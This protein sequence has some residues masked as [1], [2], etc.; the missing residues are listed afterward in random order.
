MAVAATA[1]AASL[2]APAMA[3]DGEGYFGADIGYTDVEAHKIYSVGSLDRLKEKDGFELGAFVGY[4]FGK[5]RTELEVAYEEFDPKTLTHVATGSVRHVGGESHITTAMIN[6]LF[7]LG[8]QDGIGL[9]IGAGVGRAFLSTDL[10]GASGAGLIND[11]D[12]AWAYQGIAEFRV[13]VTTWGEIGLKYKYLN[14]ESF[15]LHDLAGNRH[16]TEMA[17][18]TCG[19]A[20]AP[21]AAASAAASPAASAPAASGAGV[22][23]WAVHR[24]LRLG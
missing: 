4:D 21:T 1:M 19:S 13:P 18:S 20:S 23:R 11:S 8:G 3:R 12:S 16:Y 10:F 17:S 24:V 22:Q 6:E 15:H 14:T 9:S 7:D 5:L 2:A